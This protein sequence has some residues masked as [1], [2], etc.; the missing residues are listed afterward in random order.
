MP[1]Q[2][3]WSILHNISRLIPILNFLFNQF[4]PNKKRTPFSMQ[5]SNNKYT[6]TSTIEIRTRTPLNGEKIEK[7]ATSR[8]IHI[9]HYSICSARNFQELLRIQYAA[10]IKNMNIAKLLKQLLKWLHGSASPGPNH[11]HFQRESSALHDCR[12]ICICSGIENNI[13]LIKPLQDNNSQIRG[14]DSNL[15]EPKR[16]LII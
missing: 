7:L 16:N 6:N 11:L 9:F 2:C 8:P 4:S 1:S 3:H 10:G 14:I 15:I 5:S 13:L 12:T